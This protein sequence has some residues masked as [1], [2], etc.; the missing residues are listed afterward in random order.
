MLLAK[1]DELGFDDLD[2]RCDVVI[3]DTSLVTVE[4]TRGGITRRL[5]SRLHS[6]CISA[7][8]VDPDVHLKFD[9]FADAIDEI[10]ETSSRVRQIAEG[11]I[12]A[13]FR[14]SMSRSPCLGTCPI[15]R[16]QVNAAGHVKYD[17]KMNVAALG[18]D[19]WDLH[20][21]DARRFVQAPRE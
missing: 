6:T 3:K 5:A 8:H 11:S 7:L 14:L 21:I 13:D 15:Y 17:G 18:K 4:V 1:C 2:L 12:P 20:R 19:S 9:L 10:L 16:V